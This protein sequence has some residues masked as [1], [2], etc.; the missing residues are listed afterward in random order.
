MCTHPLDLAKVRLQMAPARG[1]TLVGTLIHVFKNEGFA[2]LYSGLSASVLRQ[3]TYSTVRFGV[4][5]KL[6]EV[7]MASPSSSSTPS[8]G[9]LIGL[10]MVAGGIG[11]AAGNPADVMNVRMQHDMALPSAQ[12]RNYRNA[13]E[14]ILRMTKEEGPRSLFKGL[15]PNI[16]RGV[17]MTASQVASYDGFKNMLLRT[18]AFGDTLSTHFTASFLAALTAVTVT[19]PVD[20]IKT[21]VMSA[22]G[23]KKQGFFKI[24]L[25][26]V[27]QEG[28][29]FAFRGWVPSFM[30][31]GPLT[32]VSP[33][34]H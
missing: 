16:S 26:T 17:L 6:K 31:L 20:V 25:H 29:G 28:I 15:G 10:A 23:A 11:G 3:L 13:F 5:E 4:Y 8:M 18:G 22:S 19:S 34:R 9:V 2:K 32:I 14:G 30:R 12:R 1:G 21:Q 27:Q 33:I 24:V 7:V